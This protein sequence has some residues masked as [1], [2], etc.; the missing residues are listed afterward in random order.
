MFY[1]LALK[2]SFNLFKFDEDKLREKTQIPQKY[3]QSVLLERSSGAH[4]AKLAAC[5]NP[6]TC[7][8]GSAHGLTGKFRIFLLVENYI[9]AVS[10]LIHTLVFC[11]EVFIKSLKLIQVLFRS[12]F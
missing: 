7:F 12:P 2:K 6:T 3:V 10:T 11:L 4:E 8:I 5:S 1:T 9:S